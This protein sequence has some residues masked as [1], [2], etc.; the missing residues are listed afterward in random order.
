MAKRKLSDKER[1][2]EQHPDQPWRWR[3]EWSDGVVQ[4]SA[5]T[6]AI[7]LAA[8]GLVFGG[9]SMPA[10]LAIPE[11]IE[12]G[13]YAILL[14][15]IF[16]LVGVGMLWAAFRRFRQHWRYGRLRFELDPFPGSW[17][18]RCG[19]TLHI[20]KGARLTGE[21]EISLKCE[22][23]TVRGSGKNRRTST[24]VLW[25]TDRTLSAL[26]LEGLGLVRSIP[27]EFIVERG[28]SL[29]SIEDEEENSRVEWTVGFEAPVAGQQNHL[30]MNFIV[31]VFDRGEDLKADDLLDAAGKQERQ[32]LKEEAIAAAGGTRAMVAGEEVWSFHQPSARKHS[33][34]LFIFAGAFAAVAWF[35]PV[36][37][38]QL[39]F[40]G[41]ALLFFAIIP[42]II[43]HRSELRLSGE[44]ITVRKRNWRGWRQWRFAAGEIAKLELKESMRSGD[45]RYL[46][47]TA[48]GVEGVDPEKPHPAEHFKARKARYRWQREN[49]G[50]GT[51]S[52]ET[53]NT[54]LSTPCFELE[55]AGYLL[56]TRAAEDVRDLLAERLGIRSR[57]RPT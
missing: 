51:P 11:E 30:T 52:E 29:P 18:G 17:G 3:K 37:I 35:V 39:A 20:P 7:A 47:L 8:F 2:R 12:K 43:W 13:N 48:V 42:G 54:V 36:L 23:K 49:R 31:P 41:F 16:T 21:V 9:L 19:G 57:G 38:M 53:L 14:V 10:L 33:I 25:E 22:R 55:L 40:G 5:R 15:L 24:Q 28:K 50:G 46:R 4:G 45:E 44:G 1:L 27:V 26:S 32:R 6:E 34:V 56:G